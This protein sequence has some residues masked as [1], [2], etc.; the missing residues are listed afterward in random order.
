MI[1]KGTHVERLTKKVGQVAATGRVITIRDEY[2]VE[3]QWDDGHTSIISKDAL[4]PLT[5]ANRPHKGA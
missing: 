4:T 3:V 5:E 2:Y 1:R